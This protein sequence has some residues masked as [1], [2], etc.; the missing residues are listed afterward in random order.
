MNTS[1]KSVRS[2]S[3]TLPPGSNSVEEHERNVKSILNT[4]READIIA[5]QKKSHLFAD[6]A[7]FLDHIISSEG[8]KVIQD[9]MDKI[10]SP[11]IT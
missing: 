6:S 7:L 2:P 9:K 10:T 3:M 5:S 11:K 1:V 8:M 4:L